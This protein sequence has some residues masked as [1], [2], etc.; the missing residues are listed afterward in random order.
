[1]TENLAFKRK[2]VQ[3]LSSLF[4]QTINFSIL[5]G[6]IQPN[7]S[8]QNYFFLSLCDHGPPAHLLLCLSWSSRAPPAVTSSVKI[9]S[10]FKNS[11]ILQKGI[12]TTL[13]PSTLRQVSIR[14]SDEAAL[15]VSGD[16]LHPCVQQVGWVDWEVSLYNHPHW[17]VVV[18]LAYSFSISSLKIGFITFEPMG[19]AT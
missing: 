7:I 12:Y 1:M 5:T 18:Y 15:A 9:G 16:L 17:R 8:T 19:L 2:L 3:C 14:P 11:Y 6:T 13:S 10:A 4:F